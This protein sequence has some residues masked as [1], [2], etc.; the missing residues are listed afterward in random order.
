MKISPELYWFESLTKSRNNSRDIMQWC[1][2]KIF[3]KIMFFRDR[4]NRNENRNAGRSTMWKRQVSGSFS[5]RCW[6][7]AL[8][9]S[10]CEL[11]VKMLLDSILPFSLS[12][13][14]SFS[15]RGPSS[16]GA[17]TRPR[18]ITPRNRRMPRIQTYIQIRTHT[19]TIYLCGVRA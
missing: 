15:L 18:S 19:H 5:P 11:R 1:W 7:S 10:H 9:S 3:P 4:W 8:T 13:F 2:I 14:L 12:L 6:R 17:H 16:A